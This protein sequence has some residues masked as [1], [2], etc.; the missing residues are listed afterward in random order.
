MSL[1]ILIISGIVLSGLFHLAGVAT[2]AKKSVWIIIVATWALAISIATGEI[3]E[4]GY[5]EIEK[6]KGSYSSTD[7]LIEEAMPKISTYELIMI[8]SD[9][10]KN[11]KQGSSN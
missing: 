11:K 4:K 7:K 1:G 3:K 2:G 6:L 8:K 9:F 5:K 10:N